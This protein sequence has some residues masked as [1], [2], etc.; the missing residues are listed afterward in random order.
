M[1]RLKTADTTIIAI[2]ALDVG[3]IAW[4]VVNSI[5]SEQSQLSSLWDNLISF[6]LPY[7]AIQFSAIITFY[8][9][10]LICGLSLIF[11]YG[12]LAWLNYVQLPLRLMMVI[13]SL[14][15]IF[16][17]LAKLDIEL[18]FVISITILCIT[19]IGRTAIIY[20]WRHVSGL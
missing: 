16:F 1:Q 10:I 17:L 20:R 11:R 12:K 13:P 2:G 15:P 6:G 8:A 4:I 19:E 3:Y 9:S 14:Y 5:S 7:P 18:G